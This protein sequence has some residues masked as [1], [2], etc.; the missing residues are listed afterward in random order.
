GRARGARITRRRTVPRRRRHP[1]PGDPAGPGPALRRVAGRERAQRGQAAGDERAAPA[2]ARQRAQQ[3]HR[4]APG[5]RAVLRGSR[6]LSR[7]HQRPDRR[8][9]SRPAV[10]ADPAPEGVRGLSTDTTR[11]VVGGEAPYEVVV[12]RGLL[13]E[14]P[15]MLGEKV[16]R[17]AVV[18]P[19]ALTATGEAVRADLAATGLNAI[20]IEVPDAEEQKSAQVLAYLWSVLGQ[21]GFT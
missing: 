10:R 7:R 16:A 5:P 6:Q 3:V 9:D 11:I 19:K 8:A 2:A 1:A 18:H 17:V 13:G 12:G 20:T 21:A 4:A 14:L 15:A